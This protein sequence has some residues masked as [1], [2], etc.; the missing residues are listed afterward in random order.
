MLETFHREAE[1]II[2]QF[3]APAVDPRL[4]A[5]PSKPSHASI[6]LSTSPSSPHHQQPQQQQQQGVGSSA[7]SGTGAQN[8]S[9]NTNPASGNAN[10]NSSNASTGAATSNNGTG[11]AA[12]SPSHQGQGQGQGQGQN[13]T[14]GASTS[15]NNS[16][17]SHGPEAKSPSGHDD[18]WGMYH[19]LI[20]MASSLHPIFLTCSISLCLP[21]LLC[22]CIAFCCWQFNVFDRIVCCSCL[23]LV[24]C[25]CHRGWIAIT[26]LNATKDS[27]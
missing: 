9:S 27:S 15:S 19:S 3:L 11:S 10:A 16:S 25:S 13:A 23:L 20:T 7:N 22:H 24:S 26:I 12:N 21:V 14:S 1:R 17:A 4:S 8:G 2:E 6:S 18:P 5:S